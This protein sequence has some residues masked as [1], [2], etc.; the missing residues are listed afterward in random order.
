MIQTTLDLG[1]EPNNES[2]RKA[3]IEYNKY[4][5]SQKQPVFLVYCNTTKNFSCFPFSTRAGIESYKKSFKIVMSTDK[6]N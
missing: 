6:L 3:L 2:Y 5:T 4:A 1:I